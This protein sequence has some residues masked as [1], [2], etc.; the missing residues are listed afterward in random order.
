[1]AARKSMVTFGMVAIPID[2]SKYKDEYQKRLRELIEIKISG[3]EI[4]STEPDSSAKVIGLMEALKASIEKAKNDK[5][6][7]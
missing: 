6:S 1:M 3:K 4:V 2:A 7:A 5:E